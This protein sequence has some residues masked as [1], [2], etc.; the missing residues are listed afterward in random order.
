MID[1]LFRLVLAGGLMIG[2]AYLPRLTTG[3]ADLS[4]RMSDQ[5]KAFRTCPAPRATTVRA[6]IA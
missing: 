6:C 2:T 1:M 5:A 3:E 4:P